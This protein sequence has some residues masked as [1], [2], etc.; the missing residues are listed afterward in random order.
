MAGRGLAVGAA[1]DLLRPY[2]KG[3]AGGVFR[4]H[5]AF[6]RDHGACRDGGAMLFWQPDDEGPECAATIGDL[7]RKAS[8]R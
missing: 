8:T 7:C 6:A 4:A 5:A 1:K 3:R 2:L